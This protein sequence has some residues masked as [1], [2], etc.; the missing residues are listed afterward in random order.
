MN[1]SYYLK[2]TVYLRR[3]PSLCLTLVGVSVKLMISLAACMLCRMASR[4]I[5]ASAAIECLTI[6]LPAETYFL[7]G[8]Y[9]KA[10]EQTD[11]AIATSVELGDRWCLPRIH[12]VREAAEA[13]L[14]TAVDIAAAQSAKGAQLQAANSLV[15]LWRDQGK[16]EKARELLAPIYSWFTQGFDTRDLKE[17]KALLDAVS[18]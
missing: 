7:S 16:T 10:T 3:A 14:Q 11:L 17:A 9:E 13:S 1:C 4:S 2:S 8:Q 15:R 12:M 18:S 5:P 6:C